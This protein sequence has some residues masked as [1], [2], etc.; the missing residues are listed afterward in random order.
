MNYKW[1]ETTDPKN[2][3]S[4]AGEWSWEQPW[5]EGYDKEHCASYT[6][7]FRTGSTF[8]QACW[9]ASWWHGNRGHGLGTGYS[10]KTKEAAMAACVAHLRKMADSICA[11]RDGLP[12][13]I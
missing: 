8:R 2:P 6:V 4:K 5:L 10:Y 3:L 9:E 12:P 7:R 13:P 1:K 11:V